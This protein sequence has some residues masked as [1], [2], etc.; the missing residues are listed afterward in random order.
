VGGGGMCVCAYESAYVR[1]LVYVSTYM[2]CVMLFCC[3][4]ARLM[5]AGAFYTH[6]HTRTHR[7][8]LRRM[9]PTD[10]DHRCPVP[11]YAQCT[12]Q[13]EMS[14]AGLRTLCVAEKEI[15]EQ[16]FEAW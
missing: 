14:Q 1:Q 7:V 5:Y 2:S 3:A 4:C 15:S 6:T 8:A 9:V 16:D 10:N 13:E 12:M 11:Y